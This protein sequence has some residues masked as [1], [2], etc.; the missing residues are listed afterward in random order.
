MFKRYIGD[1]AFYRSALHIAIPTL[2]QSIITQSVGL[3]D[4]KPNYTWRVYSN[5]AIGEVLEGQTTNTLVGIPGETYVCVVTYESGEVLTSDPITYAEK[6]YHPI[7]GEMCDCGEEHETVEFISVTSEAE[8]IL[9]AQ[10][11]GNYYLYTDIE[12]FNEILVTSDMTLDLNGK[13]LKYVGENKASV[14]E[15]AEGATLT[16]ADGADAE[17]NG[18]IDPESGLWTEDEYSGEG[19][20]VAVTLRGGMITGGNASFGGAVYVLGSLK[21]YGGNLVNNT[22]GHGGAVYVATGAVA[23]ISNVIF[24]GNLA[25]LQG[26]AIRI[27]ETEAILLDCVFVG[28][29]VVASEAS[30]DNQGGALHIY[31]SSAIIDNCEFIANYSAYRG[32]AIYATQT[33]EEGEIVT[34]NCS[35]SGNTSAENGGAI[36]LTG[37]AVYRDGEAG[38]DKGSSFFGN[39]TA[40]SGGAVCIYGKASLYSSL[41]DGNYLTGTGNYSYMGG[42]VAVAGGSAVVEGASFKNNKATSSGGAIAAYGSEIKVVLND[43]YFES[44]EASNGGAIYAGGAAEFTVTKITAKS[45]K[46]GSLGA[47]VYVTS[48]NSVLTL[49]SATLYNNN[50]AKN[51]SCGLSDIGNASAVLNI[52]KDSVVMLDV[53]NDT[54]ID[55]TDWSQ[56]LKNSKGGAINELKADAEV[57][58]E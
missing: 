56:L 57:Y 33:P 15:I 42:A 24:A 43:V 4:N 20:A 13:I 44:N 26:G 11:G 54:E 28:N 23:E 3:L 36:Y 45:N 14:I 32:G 25:T 55:I 22:A 40:V 48:A 30:T 34:N 27:Y 52:Y 21:T 41:F 53:E 58:Y 12:I 46:A 5:G 18:Y 17:R 16:L 35:F 10:L 19:N 50:T 1:R 9:A 49:N 47:V 2:I 8:L 6:I 51:I 7:C 37:T 38:A 39:S 31:R 29:R